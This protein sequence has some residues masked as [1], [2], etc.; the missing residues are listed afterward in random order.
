[1]TVA[2]ALTARGIKPARDHTLRSY[3]SKLGLNFGSA[4]RSTNEPHAVGE[5]SPPRVGPPGVDPGAYTAQGVCLLS[6]M[7]ST[8]RIPFSPKPQWYLVTRSIFP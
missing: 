2:R 3:Q 1:M 4:I 7:L 6:N 5:R 8:A